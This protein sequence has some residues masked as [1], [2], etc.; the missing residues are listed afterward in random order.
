MDWD[1]N[2]HDSEQQPLASIGR[3]YSGLMREVFTDAGDYGVYFDDA[4]GP[5]MSQLALWQGAHTLSADEASCPPPPSPAL[6]PLNKGPLSLPE[7][8]VVLASAVAVDFDYFTRHTTAGYASS[9]TRPSPGPAAHAPG[10]ARGSHAR[11][12]HCRCALMYTSAAGLRP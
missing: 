4:A 3:R 1:F 9:R 11:D 2:V 6:P 5:G 10:L 12:G 8:A 7:R